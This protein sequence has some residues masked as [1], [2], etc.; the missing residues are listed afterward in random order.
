MKSYTNLFLSICIFSLCFSKLVFAGFSPPPLP[1]STGNI[2]ERN[3][4]SALF[5]AC[6]A[7][8]LKPGQ[9][10]TDCFATLGA[11]DE[12]IGV[13]TPDEIF[14]NDTTITNNAVN[15]SFGRLHLLRQAGRGGGASADNSIVN[16]LGVYINGHT[17]WE[18]YHEQGL[19]PGFKIFNSKV[20]AGVDHRFS[21]YFIAGLSASYINSDNQFKNGA[22]DID[23]DGY[24]FAIYG[25]FNPNEYFFIDGS[26]GYADQRHSISRNIVFTGANQR[27][28]ADVDSDTFSAGL[29]T[30]Y[31]FYVGGWTIT[32]TARWMYRNIQLD[33]YTEAML[34]P[35]AAGGSLGLAVGSQEYESITGNFG[36]QI[37]YAWNQSWGVLI[38]TFS[39]EYVYEFQDNSEKVKARFINAP[40][41]TGVFSIENSSRD[42]D[43]AAISAGFS[44][45]FIHNISAFVMYEKLLG[46]KSI[47][48]DSLSMGV[49]LEFD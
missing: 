35:T 36:T 1:P 28:D 20:T 23:V 9:F 38:P 19:N 30:G 18:E 41:G 12:S 14:S 15:Q 21:D 10:R 44:A 49:R 26:F 3:T 34:N 24:S 6:N 2:N 17:S 4:G 13:L 22:G 39:A 45:Q 46:L 8:R 33:K 5:D 16:Q 48:S 42:S 7:D 40:G 29:T 25:S 32:P 47:T 37:S 11:G 31:N 27:T 43:Y